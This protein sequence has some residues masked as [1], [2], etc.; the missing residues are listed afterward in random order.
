ME[1]LPSIIPKS[2]VE[3]LN[4]LEND[5]DNL[6]SWKLTRSQDKFSLTVS[7]KLPAKTC[8]VL[9]SIN[10]KALPMTLYIYILHASV[11]RISCCGQFLLRYSLK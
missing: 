9:Y 1:G 10:A 5:E 8:N 3:V 7:C 6:F 2:I 11:T 4:R